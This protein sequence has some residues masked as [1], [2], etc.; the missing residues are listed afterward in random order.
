ML[1]AFVLVLY[2]LNPQG[3]STFVIDHSMTIEDCTELRDEWQ[4][5]TDKF[6]TVVCHPEYDS[7]VYSD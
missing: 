2:V 1:N 7:P 5:T 4:A 3:E 6:S